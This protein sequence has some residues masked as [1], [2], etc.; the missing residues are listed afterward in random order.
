[1]EKPHVTISKRDAQRKCIP[2]TRPPK[3]AS[4]A[5]DFARIPAYKVDPIAAVSS[6]KL[7]I[8]PNTAPLWDGFAEFAITD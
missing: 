4:W 3:I 8:A 2:G 7:P 6:V 1:M 5:V